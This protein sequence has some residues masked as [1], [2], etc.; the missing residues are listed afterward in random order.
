MYAYFYIV[1]KWSAAESAHQ[2]DSR[3]VWSAICVHECGKTGC[4]HER[5]AQ[6]VGTD[7]IELADLTAGML[8]CAM[9]MSLND[10][11]PYQPI[12]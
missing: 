4:L 2:R 5:W 1:S 11:F 8:G 6:M 10:A 12:L 9:C 3:V 7:M